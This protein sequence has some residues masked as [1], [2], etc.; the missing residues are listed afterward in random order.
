MDWEIKNDDILYINKN[1]KT[2]KYRM[3]YCTNYENLLIYKIKKFRW[4]KPFFYDEDI[5]SM[6]EFK[7]KLFLTNSSKKGF[8]FLRPNCDNLLIINKEN[9]EMYINNELKEFLDS[10]VIMEELI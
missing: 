1:N 3:F 7:V 5:L 9:N 6:V 10:R 4:F 8:N 2:I